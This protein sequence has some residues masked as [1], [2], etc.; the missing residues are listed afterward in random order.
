MHVFTPAT[1]AAYLNAA[2]RWPKLRAL[3]SL[4]WHQGCRPEELLAVRSEHVDLT[5]MHLHTVDGKTNA[6][7]RKLRIRPEWATILVR[8]LRDARSPFLFRSERSAYGQLSL[9]KCENWH[10]KVREATGIRA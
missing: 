10:V 4:M 8:L 1:E 3:A 5:R 7:K 6:A 2:E 9:S